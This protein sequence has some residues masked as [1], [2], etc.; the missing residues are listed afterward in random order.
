M[1][2]R[3]N[4]KPARR[5]VSAL[6]KDV[7]GGI[8][9]KKSLMRFTAGLS[10]AFLLSIAASAQV[11]SINSAVV[12]LRVFN[13][14]PT[15]L[16]TAVNNYP[17]TISFD[18]QSLDNG[19]NGGFANRHQWEFSNDS[20]T[21][22][23][24]ANDDFFESF[25]DVTLTANPTSPRKEAGFLLSTVGGQGQ[26]IVNT[27]AREVVAFGGPLP[28]FAFPS[29]FD[30]G[31]TLRLGL[32]YFRDTDGL[33]KIIYHAGAASS[34]AL[35]FDNLE[36]GIIGGST[37]G[38]YGQFG[39]T[40]NPLNFGTASF[41][42]ITITSLGATAAPEPASIVLMLFGTAV[43]AVKCRARRRL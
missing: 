2:G 40:N 13:D 32:T 9:M 22:Y 21:P 43:A 20:A 39:I 36:Q 27:D 24:F 3:L 38:G 28:F 41:Q 34:P 23:K 11:S 12:S 33:R 26:F 14:D 42:N 35:A 10:L 4:E 7:F 1:E 19:G 16:L 5:A 6:Y 31:E 8:E 30:S 29:N 15:S 37:L 17:S 25:V 18:D